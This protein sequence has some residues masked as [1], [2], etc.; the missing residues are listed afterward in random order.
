M[1][2]KKK[3]SRRYYGAMVGRH[4]RNTLLKYQGTNT[5]TGRTS[6]RKTSAKFVASDIK[7]KGFTGRIYTPKASLYHT[8]P[9]FE[10]VYYSMI[11]YR[12]ERAELY[13]RYRAQKVIIA[14]LRKQMMTYESLRSVKNTGKILSTVKSILK[15]KKAPMTSETGQTKIFPK[16]SGFKWHVDSM[17]K[18]DPNR[19]I[20]KSE[21]HLV[22]PERVIKEGAFSIKPKRKKRAL[23]FAPGHGLTFQDSLDSQ[24]VR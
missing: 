19:P 24:V 7:S 2:N 4:R 10:T 22:K 1:T 20:L 16:S 15:P 13:W 11:A 18:E 9:P 23:K 8:G 14:N 21:R 17:F 3:G 6:T 12:K 5:H